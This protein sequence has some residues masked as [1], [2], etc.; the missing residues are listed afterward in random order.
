MRPRPTVVA[1]L[2][3]ALVGI[4]TWGGG[5]AAGGAPRAGAASHPA[6]A[7][8]ASATTLAQSTAVIA[9]GHLR[10]PGNTFWELFLR[11]AGSPSWVLH[12]P[13]G[14]ASNGG[15]VVA[16]PPAGSLTVGFLTSADLKF[17]PVAQRPDGGTSWCP[18]P[19]PSGR[20]ARCWPW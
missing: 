9:M 14:V 18:T 11:P 7:I 4:A 3:A 12:T 20:R 10:D 8:A 13:P 1:G 2:S 19:W 15:L 5:S 17:S 16:A 6:P